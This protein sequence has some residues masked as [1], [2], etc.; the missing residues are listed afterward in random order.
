MRKVQLTESQLKRVIFESAMK[1]VEQYKEYKGGLSPETLSSAYEK[2]KKQKEGNGKR[3]RQAE[4]F[5][6]ATGDKVANMSDKEYA[7]FKKNYE[8]KDGEGYK[9]KKNEGYRRMGRRL[10]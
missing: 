2:A 10:W 6:N 3:M 1:L 8:Y 9:K 7:E 5:G 4:K